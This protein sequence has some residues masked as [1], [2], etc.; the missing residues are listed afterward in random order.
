M[1]SRRPVNPFP[2]DGRRGKCAVPLEGRNQTIASVAI[3]DAAV[4]VGV[5]AEA[6]PFKLAGALL[7]G[8][9][10]LALMAGFVG[11]IKGLAKMR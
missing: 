1:K 6:L 4:A 10:V 8:V 7:F 2:G 11:F 5:V 9:A 3:V